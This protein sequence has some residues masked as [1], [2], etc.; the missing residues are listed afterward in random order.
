MR[1]LGER[2]IILSTYNWQFQPVNFWQHQPIGAGV[3][4]QHVQGVWSSNHYS[5]P[6][7]FDHRYVTY[8]THMNYQAILVPHMIILSRKHEVSMLWWFNIGTPSATLVQHQTGTSRVFLEF[9]FQSQLPGISRHWYQVF[10]SAMTNSSKC[11]SNLNS[12][13]L[14]LYYKINYDIVTTYNFK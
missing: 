1:W 9:F 6:A 4:S 7:P 5:F 3:K 12:K 14:V 2:F 13:H 8:F 10:C 11:S